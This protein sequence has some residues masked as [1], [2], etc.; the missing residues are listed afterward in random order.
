MNMGSSIA[1]LLKLTVA[2]ILQLGVLGTYNYIG[3]HRVIADK[4]TDS[5]YAGLHP[6]S[7]LFFGLSPILLWW[8]FRVFYSM[9]GDSYWVAFM[10]GTVL[11]QVSGMIAGYLASRQIPTV[12]QIIA[13]TLVI[14]GVVISS[15]RVK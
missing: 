2:V 4:W 8:S 6:L 9:T 13:L 15:I 5:L 12:P 7:V 11:A 1:P 14:A 10:M 3:T